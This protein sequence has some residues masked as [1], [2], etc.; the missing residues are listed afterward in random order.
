MVNRFRSIIFLGLSL[1]IITG[2]CYAR[3]YI[4][5]HGVKTGKG[6]IVYVNYSNDSDD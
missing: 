6:V 5:R 4:E 1:L 2:F 3:D